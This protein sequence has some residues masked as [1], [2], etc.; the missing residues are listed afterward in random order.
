MNKRSDAALERAL[1]LDPN[2]I[3]ADAWLIT[4]WVEKGDLAK[5]YQH[6]RRW[7]SGIRRV[8]WPTSRWPTSCAMAERWKNLRTNVTLP[9]PWIRA[10]IM[11]RSCAFTFEQLGNYARAVDFLQLDAG[12][13]LGIEQSRAALRCDGKLAQARE[14]A[15]KFRLSLGERWVDRDV[16]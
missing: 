9:W 11:L 2:Y 16:A 15:Q 1:R 6:G 4:N 10:T 8:R 13:T 5:A 3:F 14:L 12:F 7:W